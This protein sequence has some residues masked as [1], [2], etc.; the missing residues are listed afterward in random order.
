MQ[1]ATPDPARRR[2]IVGALPA[3]ALVCLGCTGACR[4]SPAAAAE[5]GAE[6][7]HKFDADSQMSYAELFAFAFKSAYIPILQALRDQLGREDYVDLLKQAGEAAGRVGGK[8]WAQAAPTNDFS[9]FK[10]S[11]LQPNRFFKHA[12]AWKVLEN[13][14]QAFEVSITECLWAKTFRDAEAA[15]IGYATVCHQ[16]YA[17]AP[18]YNPKMRRERTKTLRE[19]DEFCN[20]RW[21]WRA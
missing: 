19:G 8:N 21:L 16:D 3:G 13:S 6:E 15:D 2:F 11:L 10:A 9:S 5:D 17:V 14:D 12:L 7:G 20:H 1:G 4:V 18:A